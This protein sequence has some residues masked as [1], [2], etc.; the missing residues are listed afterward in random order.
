M[1]TSILK[2]TYRVYPASE[3]YLYHETIACENSCLCYGRGPCR[4]TGTSNATGS[5]ADP[6]PCRSGAYTTRGPGRYPGLCHVRG[7]GRLADLGLRDDSRAD[8][9]R[10]AHCDCDVCKGN[11]VLAFSMTLSSAR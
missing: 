8:P 3:T 2:E 7:L 5:A 6:D 11:A 4:E 10:H 9:D 1:V